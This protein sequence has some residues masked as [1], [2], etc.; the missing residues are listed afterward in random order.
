M[1]QSTG[2]HEAFL[3]PMGVSPERMDGV[4]ERAEERRAWQLANPP[5]EFFYASSTSTDFGDEAPLSLPRSPP[6]QTE[7]TGPCLPGTHG[8]LAC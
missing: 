7:N 8:G 6:P 5:S 4:K 3:K 1:A 2:D